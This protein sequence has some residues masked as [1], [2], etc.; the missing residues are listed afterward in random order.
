MKIGTWGGHGG[1][2]CD[3]KRSPM[4]LTDI[5]VRSDG[6]CINSIEFTYMDKDGQ[7]QDEGPWGGYAGELKPPVRACGL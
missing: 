5:T 4:R 7:L 2:P 3:I 6:E 1:Q